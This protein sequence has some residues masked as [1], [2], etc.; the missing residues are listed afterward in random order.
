MLSRKNIYNSRLCGFGLNLAQRRK[1]LRLTQ[2][3][4]AERLSLSPET[5]ARFERGSY[6]PSLP[7]LF[8]L[9]Q[10]L[11]CDP[12]SLLAG[13]LEVREPQPHQRLMSAL[14]GLESSELDHIYNLVVLES[15]FLRKL[16]KLGQ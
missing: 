14:E 15:Q 8:K 4:L 1:A 9:A 7:L 5:V 13:E 6:L 10:I 11:S 3:E 16:R 2:A 12:T